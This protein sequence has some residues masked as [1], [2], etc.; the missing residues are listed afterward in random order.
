MYMF[1]RVWRLRGLCRRKRC[2]V[3]GALLVDGVNLRQV[4]VVPGSLSPLRS[5]LDR[6]VVEPWYKV[7]TYKCT[8][9]LTASASSVEIVPGQRS[10]S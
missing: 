10:E 3:K 5:L 6:C 2:G 9:H 4:E 8:V 7:Y 1:R